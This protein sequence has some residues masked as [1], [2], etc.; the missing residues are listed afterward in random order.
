[1]PYNLNNYALILSPQ[2]AK[3]EVEK[4]QRASILCVLLSCFFFRGKYT[5]ASSA[6]QRAVGDPKRGKRKAR[7][8]KV[9]K[10]VRCKIATSFD[11]SGHPRGSSNLKSTSTRSRVPFPLALHLVV[12][13]IL[14]KL[15]SLS[16]FL[17]AEHENSVRRDRRKDGVFWW[18]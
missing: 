17:L 1:M 7:T 14:P 12:L 3:L 5:K 6:P 18:S 4:R 16:V 11:A 2:C 8:E 13:V 15:S 10:E 9:R